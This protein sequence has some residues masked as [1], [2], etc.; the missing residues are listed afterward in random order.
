MYRA[1]L[2]HAHAQAPRWFFEAHAPFRLWLAAIGALG[3]GMAASLV[4]AAELEVAPVIV[5][6]APGQRAAALTISNPG[7][8]AMAFQIRAYAWSQTESGDLLAATEELLVSP[9][10]GSL[11]TGVSQVVRLVLRRVPAGREATYRI[12]VDE[13][14]P[15]TAPGTVRIALRQ[16]IPIFAEPATRVAT[17]LRWRVERAGE[18]AW[19]VALNDGSRHAEVRDIA[20]T[21]PG[22][23]ALPVDPKPL[24]YLL[25]GATLRWRIRAPNLAPG[26]VLRLTARVD[27]ADLDERV[28]VDRAIPP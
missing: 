8:S 20:L 19:L 12:L 24:P 27:A 16:S 1:F 5:Q 22:G 13:I 2:T 4:A 10:L 26:Q 17:K 14:P 11:P 18:V 21:V 15:P 28:A 23:D 25:V 6:M 7:D 3:V 9:P